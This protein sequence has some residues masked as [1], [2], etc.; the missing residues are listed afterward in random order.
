MKLRTARQVVGDVF[1]AGVYLV[2]AVI[3]FDQILTRY[4]DFSR[5]EFLALPVV[6][7]GPLLLYMYRLFKPAWTA[8]RLRKKRSD[9]L[10][11]DSPKMQAF[12]PFT[13]L[14]ANEGDRFGE[15][16]SVLPWNVG[17]LLLT[18]LLFAMLW[19][20]DEGSRLVWHVDDPESAAIC[21][22]R[23][24]LGAENAYSS[25]KGRY[26]TLDMLL[27]EK[28]HFRGEEYPLLYGKWTGVKNGYRF[29]VTVDNDGKSFKAIAMPENRQMRAFYVD[30][31]G[32]IRCE[33]EGKEA[34][35]ES[36][37]I[38]E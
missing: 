19:P 9:T 17:L 4:D 32:V 27:V 24:I 15:R 10:A 34:N 11:E 38:G 16:G 7:I 21:I 5:L 30:Q 26:G 18:L 23:T 36:T 20:N 29:T 14:S 35:A 1:F 25:A 33:K 22:I 28:V 37:P 8:L 31:T 6:S 3:T 12:S 2:L 13:P